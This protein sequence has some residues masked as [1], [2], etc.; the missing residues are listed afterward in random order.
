MYKVEW[1]KERTL[2]I[3]KF[4]KEGKINKIQFDGIWYKPVVNNNSY[5]R[6]EFGNRYIACDGCDDCALVDICHNCNADNPIGNA[7]GEFGISPC[8]MIYTTPP[9]KQR[10][11][12][13]WVRR[14]IPKEEWD[15]W[16]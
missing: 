3:L 2:K 9:N 4:Y 11:L 14:H 12:S 16:R 5:E 15:W 10:K 6:D 8:Y 1:N 7:C 13:M